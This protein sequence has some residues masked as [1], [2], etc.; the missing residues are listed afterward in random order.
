MLLC[1]LSQAAHQNLNS[2]SRRTKGRNSSSRCDGSVG[3]SSSGSTCVAA[4]PIKGLTEGIHFCSR[5]TYATEQDAAA[6]LTLA[7]S[8]AEAR[9]WLCAA[10]ATPTSPVPSA[11][12]SIF[13]G[14]LA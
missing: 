4:L 7:D 9:D 13:P 3:P 5:A 2:G 10:T 12:L 1:M 14:S 8:A 6:F 11:L